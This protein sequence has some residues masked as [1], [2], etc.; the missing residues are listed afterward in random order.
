MLNVE[1]PKNDTISAI[2]LFQNPT[3][4]RR[5][6]H[7]GNDQTRDIF[8]AKPFRFHRDINL[9]A[10]FNRPVISIQPYKLLC[11]TLGRPGSKGLVVRTRHNYMYQ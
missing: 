3:V 1:R 5:R 9:F 10:R 7:L 4:V 8:Y 2:E 11:G 6:N